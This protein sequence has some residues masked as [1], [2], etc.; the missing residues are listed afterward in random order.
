M[1]EII[2]AIALF[3]MFIVS[4]SVSAE[5]MVKDRDYS[6]VEIHWPA[7]NRTVESIMMNCSKKKDSMSMGC[8]RRHYDSGRDVNVCTIYAED[9]TDYS[10]MAATIWKHEVTHCFKGQ[11]H[12]KWSSNE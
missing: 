5:E 8:A 11:W 12:G 10:G 4:L 3:T 9:F 2:F 6:V 7:E 1:K